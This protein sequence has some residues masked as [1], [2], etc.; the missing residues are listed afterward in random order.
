MWFFDSPPGTPCPLHTLPLIFATTMQDRLRDGL[1]GM[2]P[3]SAYK[4]E[5]LRAEIRALTSCPVLSV[6]PSCYSYT[7][8]VLVLM[9]QG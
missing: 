6:P 4:V 7:A 3:R 1:G 5:G 2:R 8:V 9:P